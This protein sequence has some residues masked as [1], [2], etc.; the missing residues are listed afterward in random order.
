MVPSEVEHSPSDSVEIKASE[1]TSPLA[2]IPCVKVVFVVV[3][4]HRST[5]VKRCSP[6]R[7]WCR[8]YQS[9]SMVH[10]FLD[11]GM[12]EGDVEAERE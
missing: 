7:L 9:V 10:V 1:T 2:Q 6:C 8:C 3:V 4:R 12:V 11:E 5:K